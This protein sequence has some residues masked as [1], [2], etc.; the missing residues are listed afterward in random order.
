M[1]VFAPPRVRV[2]LKKLT[3]HSFFSSS[4]PAPVH[5]AAAVH[6]VKIRR[7]LHWSEVAADSW[8]LDDVEVQGDVR[9]SIFDRKGLPSGANLAEARQKEMDE[10]AAAGKR[11]LAGKEPGRCFYFI[12]HT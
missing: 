10:R 3:A 9:I 11:C 6:D 4:K 1:K 2:C 12:F 8:A 7:I 5:L